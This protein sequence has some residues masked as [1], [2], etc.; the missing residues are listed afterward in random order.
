MEGERQVLLRGGDYRPD[1]GILTQSYAKFVAK[2]RKVI[3]RNAEAIEVVCFASDGSCFAL[4]RTGCPLSGVKLQPP[5]IAGGTDRDLSFVPYR[6]GIGG[7][8]SEG[9]ASLHL[10]L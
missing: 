9:S 5:A 7:R 6:D 3:A 1:R 2:L 10:G 4:M 8:V